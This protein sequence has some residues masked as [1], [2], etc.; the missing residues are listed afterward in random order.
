MSWLL[1]FDK[2]RLTFYLLNCLLL[3]RYLTLLKNKHKL[4]VA[5]TLYRIKSKG[6]KLCHLKINWIKQLVLSRRIW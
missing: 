6:D 1:S 4:N 5:I 2:E 3:S